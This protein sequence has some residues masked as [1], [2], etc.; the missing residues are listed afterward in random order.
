MKS[1]EITDLEDNKNKE[2][3]PENR[4][5]EPGLLRQIGVFPEDTQEGYN[6][7]RGD[8]RMTAY[9]KVSSII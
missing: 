8:R 9:T 7:R 1:V 2:R 6:G 4:A 5:F 3:F